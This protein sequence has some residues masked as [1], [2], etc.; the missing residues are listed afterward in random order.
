MD[1]KDIK[2][3]NEQ[4]LRKDLS[5]LREKL[6]EMRFKLGF[7]EMKNTQEIAQVRKTIAR[8]MTV[9]KERSLTK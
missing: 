7:K 8:I 6:R 2:A 5:A 1:L 3:K 4:E 9:L